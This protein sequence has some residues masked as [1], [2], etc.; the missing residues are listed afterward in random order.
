MTIR[1]GGVPYGV[2]APLLGGLE[3]V[4]GVEL[5]REPPTSMI[6]MLRAGELDAAL[7][8]SVEAIRHPGYTVAAGLGIACKEEIRSVRAFRRRGRPIRTVGCDSSSATTVA[9]LRLLLHHVHAAEV[10]G[11]PEFETVTPT[12]RPDELDHD[13]VMMIGDPGLEADP[14]EREVWDLGTEWVRWIITAMS[15]SRRGSASIQLSTPP[16]STTR[17][18]PSARLNRMTSAICLASLAWM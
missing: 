5:L 14:G 11:A 2:G 15:F 1:I 17:S 13:L 7:L 16:T 6:P 12:R 18:R 8:S 10:D 3:A 9:L 4:D